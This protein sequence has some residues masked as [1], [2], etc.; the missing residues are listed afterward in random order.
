MRTLSAP[1]DAYHLRTLVERMVREGRTEDEIV[2]AVEEAETRPTPPAQRPTRRWPSP[3]DQRPAIALEGGHEGTSATGA[4][5]P[6]TASPGSR[7]RLGARRAPT[8]RD[9]LR[10]HATARQRRGSAARREGDCVVRLELRAERERE[11]RP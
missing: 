6:P 9:G 4:R 11:I 7:N 2:A 10:R 5:R 8:E 3:A 1:A